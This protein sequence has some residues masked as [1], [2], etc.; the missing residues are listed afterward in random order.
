MNSVNAGKH[1]PLH[2]AAY[3]GYEDIILELL[4]R[5]AGPHAASN[6]KRTPLHEACMQGM[7][8]S[9][10]PAITL[11][12]L[13]PV[14]KREALSGTSVL[15]CTEFTWQVLELRTVCRSFSKAIENVYRK[16]QLKEGYE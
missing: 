9:I 4:L 2:E 12:L 14:F 7:L 15:L 16:A 13:A 1:T 3:R 10:T 6:Q 5:G 8:Y 11:C